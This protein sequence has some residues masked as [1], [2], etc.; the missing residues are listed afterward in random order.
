MFGFVYCNASI[1]ARQNTDPNLYFVRTLTKHWL[2]PI[3]TFFGV[4][5]NILAIIV[6][7]KR[8]M[9]MSSTNNYLVALAIVDIAYLLLTLIINTLQNPCFKDTSLTEIILTIS[10]PIVDFSS[11]SSVW[12]TVTFTVERWVAITYPLQSRTW[13]T[14]YRARKIILSVLCASL[15]CTL[16]SAFE[17]KLERIIEKKNISN[18]I[19]Y[20]SYIKAT[21]TALGNSLLYHQIYF[22]FVT[23]AIIWIPLLLL[24]IFNTIL[25][26]YVRRSKQDQRQNREGILLRRHNRG[27][28]SEQRK[29][30]IML[31]AVVIVFTVCQIPQAISLTVQSIFPVSAQTSEVLIYN[32][33]AN[34]FVA[35]NASSNFLLYCC[36]SDRF[37]SI[38]RSNFTFLNKYCVYFIQPKFRITRTHQRRINSNSLDNISLTNQ[39]FYSLHGNQYHTRVSNLSIDMNSKYFHPINQ[40]QSHRIDDNVQ[41]WFVTHLSNL[42]LKLKSTKRNN[43]KLREINFSQSTES[44]VSSPTISMIRN[45]SML[46]QQKRTSN[47]S[48]CDDQTL[49]L[50][51]DET[52]SKR[53]AK[54]EKLSLTSSKRQSSC[55]CE[56][57][58]SSLKSIPNSKTSSYHSLID[59]NQNQEHIWIKRHRSNSV[60]E[61]LLCRQNITNSTEILDVTV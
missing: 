27:N 36:F 37:R 34:C 30:T 54:T 2:W 5:G 25:I 60:N 59:N 45:P 46:I 6:L 31:I 56:S 13:C 9:I 42:S 22:N 24:I 49:R 18:T 3:I 12:L 10:R 53:I 1:L 38:F 23:F 35:I 29:T 58:Q 33:F 55:V 32:N 19:I 50:S 14:V 4:T 57:N 52:I 61:Q 11:N 43:I 44:Y 16:P 51:V 8:R 40:R 47:I 41:S 26:S 28:H 17:M 20:T 39:S 21:P 48:T 7:T 15:I